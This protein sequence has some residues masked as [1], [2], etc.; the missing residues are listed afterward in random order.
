[1]TP[2][3]ANYWKDLMLTSK[4]GMLSVNMC[5]RLMANYQRVL[6][7]PTPVMSQAQIDLKISEFSEIYG[8][9]VEAREGTLDIL[10]AA[11]ASAKATIL[12]T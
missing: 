8:L 3:W 11:W 2:G 12:N 1:M 7:L 5:K 10:R 6:V 9:S 4:R